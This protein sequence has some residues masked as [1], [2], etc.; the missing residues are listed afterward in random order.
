MILKNLLSVNQLYLKKVIPINPQNY[1]APERSHATEELVGY[2]E[3]RGTF[4][5]LHSGN[6]ADGHTIQS[7]FF[8]TVH[9]RAHII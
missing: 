6:F 8:V 1:K 9:K 2:K 5:P 7:R 4:W 3:Q